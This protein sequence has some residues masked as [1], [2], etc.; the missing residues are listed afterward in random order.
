MIEIDGLGMTVGGTAVFENCSAA[1]ESGT[2]TLVRGVSGSGKTTLVRAIAQLEQYSGSIRFDGV[3]ASHVRDRL[4]ACLDDA[5]LIPYLNGY[6]NVRM[7]AGRA[8]SNDRIR[9]AAPSVAG[10]ALL[11]RAAHELSV[12]QRKRVHLVAAV[13]GRADYLVFDD[14]LSGIDA[15]TVAELA[16]ALREP[17]RG[18]T[19]LLT[20]RPDD[21]LES[22]ASHQL[23]IAKCQLVAKPEVARVLA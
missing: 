1:L 3:E 23:L 2:V 22:V 16:P 20:A 18:A 15:P 8:D 9:S 14:I 13:C 6:D 21:G 12:G 10:D 4:Y 11:R 7:L 17:A 19:V 5:P